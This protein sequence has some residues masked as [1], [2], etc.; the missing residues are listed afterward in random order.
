LRSP[1]TAAGFTACG[2]LPDPQPGYPAASRPKPD[3]LLE[4][5]SFNLAHA[6]RSVLLFKQQISLAGDAT[7]SEFALVPGA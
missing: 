1:T 3:S 5:I 4:R 6:R 7:R 2:W